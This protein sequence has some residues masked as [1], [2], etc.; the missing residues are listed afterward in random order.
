MGEHRPDTAH[1]HTVAPCDIGNACSP[2]HSPVG[3]TTPWSLCGNP[4]RTRILGVDLLELCFRL[5]VLC[6]CCNGQ[7]GCRSAWWRVTGP[8]AMRV[9]SPAARVGPA[10]ARSVNMTSTTLP[11]I[12]A[13]ST[14]PP[15]TSHTRT[16]PTST[17]RHP[18]RVTCQV[19]A[20]TFVLG[21]VESAVR[22]P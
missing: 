14:H 10:V 20:R 1:P 15:G 4:G 9:D 6:G 5:L 21:R 7:L 12:S 22:R 17:H 19:G 16:R 8:A 11:R 3:R 18:T 2:N 13:A